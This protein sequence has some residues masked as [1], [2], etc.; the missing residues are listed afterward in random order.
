MLGGVPF[1]RLL[2]G[3]GPDQIAGV[4]PGGLADLFASCHSGDFF[5]AFDTFHASDARE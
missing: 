2:G 5:H 1:A 3:A 4:A